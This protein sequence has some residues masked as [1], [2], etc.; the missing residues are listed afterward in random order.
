MPR[1]LDSSKTGTYNNCSR[2]VGFVKISKDM[3][4]FLS[5]GPEEK[6]GFFTFGGQWSELSNKGVRWL[7][8]L[9]GSDNASR[10]K[11]VQVKDKIIVFF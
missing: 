7:T 1:P 4:T 2:N 10:V 6:G 9:T 11:C 5:D 8:K 3:K